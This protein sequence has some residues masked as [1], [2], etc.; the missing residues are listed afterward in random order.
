MLAKRLIMQGK[1]TEAAALADE[2]TELKTLMA[3]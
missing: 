2:T 3:E 1:P